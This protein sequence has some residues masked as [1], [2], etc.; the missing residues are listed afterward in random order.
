LAS[1]SA[2]AARAPAPHTIWTIGGNGAGCAAAPGCGDGGA[3]SSAQISFPQGVA[4]D[5]SGNVYVVDWGDNEIRKISPSG[6]ITVVAGDGTACDTVP[7]CGDGGPATSAQL[8]FPMGVAVDSH[9]DLFIADAGADEI[10]E[11][12]PNGTITRFAGV[13][14]DCPGGTCGD[15]G[16][17][18]SAQL[19]SPDGVA[20]D[21]S[22]NV[23]IADTGDNLIRKVARDGSISTVAGNGT[24]CTSTP[25]CGDGGVAVA[26]SLSFPEAVA[27]DRHGN[28]FIADNG[29]NEIREVTRGNIVRVAGS[30]TA[31]AA[32]PACGDGARATS[33]QLNAPEGVAVDGAGNLY[34][35]DWGDNEVRLVSHGTISRLAGNGAVCTPASGCGDFGSAANA[36]LGSPHGVAVDGAGNVYIGDN[37]DDVIRFVPANTT[38][39][40][41]LRGSHGSLFLLA[42]TTA[43]TSRAVT[44]RYLLS[45]AASVSLWVRQGSGRPLLAAR[46]TGVAGLQTINWNR[47]LGRQS[48]PHGRYTLTV[49]VTSG[50]LTM[51]SSITV[52]I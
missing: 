34:I 41:R 24:E 49:T 8:D 21:R 27:V 3:A 20:V 12:L 23:Y 4:V 9:G 51:S 11:V 30:G 39:P 42:F 14:D 6:T 26:A 1:S 28:L 18:R 22:G 32:A 17:A 16:L 46:A 40:A 47:R 15:G 25:S 35:A 44:V 19:T 33:A 7:N 13:G 10:R 31:C 50:R 45:G 36:Q 43:T 37:V 5:G 48:A 2:A 29:N 52:G 38:P